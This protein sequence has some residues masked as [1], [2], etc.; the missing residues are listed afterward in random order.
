M[1]PSPSTGPFKIAL[2]GTHGVGKTTLC[3]GL[4]ARLK[5]QH[6]TVEL[7]H[8]VARRCPLP[9]N[10]ETTLEA[11]RW[12]VFEQLA[13]ELVAA[14]RASV[15]LCDRS[16]LDNYAYSLLK[17]GPDPL[18]EP[19][20]EAWM[21][22]YSLLVFVP[23]RAPPFADAIRACDPRFQ[24][25]IEERIEFELDRRAIAPF[26]LIPDETACWLDQVEEQVLNLLAPKQLSLFRPRP[27]S[28]P[29]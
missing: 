27:D 17:Y 4:A 3:F 16:I 20:L 6:F 24:R 25:E 23:H 28:E 21:P 7:V 2:I 29:G 13:E 12:I 8:E 1:K 10:E 11:Q 19:L 18:L 14:T 5:Q 9:I 26:R 22:S 15:V